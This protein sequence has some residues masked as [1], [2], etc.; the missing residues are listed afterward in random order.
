MAGTYDIFYFLVSK[1][2]KPYNVKPGLG[3]KK[4]RKKDKT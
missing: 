1:R 2:P 3:G 4:E